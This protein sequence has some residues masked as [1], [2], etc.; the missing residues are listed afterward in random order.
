MTCTASVALVLSSGCSGAPPAQAAVDRP[1]AGGTLRLAQ[2]A[3][4]SLDP[5]RC[6]SVYE[7]LPINQIFDTLVAYDPSLNVVPSLAET[8]TISRDNREY[9]FTLRSDV[10]FHNGDPLT[11]GDVVFSIARQLEPRHAG[12]SLAFTYLLAIEGA[13]EY[14][15]G[16]AD[17]VAG[18]RVVDETT[19]EIRLSRP[20]PS[21]LELLAMDNMAI[22]PERVVRELG[23]FEFGRNP[24]GTGPFR[25]A[26]WGEEG[27]SLVAN[28]SYFRGA[29]HLDSVQI[30]FLG[31]EEND[32]GASRFFAEGLD[33]LEPP[34]DSLARLLDDRSVE[35]HRYQELSL[36]FLGL[37]S[38]VPPLDDRRVR[39]A[40]AH[41]LDRSAMVA[42]SPS[43]RREAVGILPPGLPGY[44]P[45]P[46]ALE[47]NPERSLRLLEQ[48]GYPRGEGLPPI[49]LH[50]A[51]Q[52]AAAKRLIA[53]IESDLAAVGIR[54][55]LVHESWTSLGKKLDERSAGAFLL[56]WIADLTDPDSFLRSMFEPNGSGN[57]F[58]HLNDET[59]RLLERGIREFDPVTRA[60]IYRRLEQQVLEQAPLVPLYHSVGI[61]AVR[62]NVHGFHPTPLGVAK[63][64]LEQVWFGRR[65]DTG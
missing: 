57:Y 7:S 58:N 4:N 1:V 28:P 14:A 59:T 39:R 38:D 32:F 35:L 9:I 20:Y 5:W 19:V 27:L 22:V 48:A 29:P 41:A 47:Y 54:L 55:E 46:K 44:S 13:P 15:R 36:S 37:N 40:I 17:G 56:A 11:A 10:R 23:A 61:I 43:F 30:G 63:V 33:V 51:S 18:L 60:R 24:I 49:R 64:D 53:F 65:G 8:W 25:I 42:D 31:N 62:D 50:T 2:E 21:F 16:D 12:I 34:V 3:P 45:E 6:S 52:S 26:Q